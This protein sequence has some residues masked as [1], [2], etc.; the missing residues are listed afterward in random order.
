M[1]KATIVRLPCSKATGSAENRAP[2]PKDTVIIAI[3]IMSNIPL[4][5][6]IE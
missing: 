4:A 1:K 2:Y 3:I 6:K 5:N